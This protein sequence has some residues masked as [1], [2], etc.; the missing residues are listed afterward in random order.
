VNKKRREKKKRELFE[1]NQR[2]NLVGLKSSKKKPGKKKNPVKL[3][4]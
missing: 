4:G 2:K 1:G 3:S